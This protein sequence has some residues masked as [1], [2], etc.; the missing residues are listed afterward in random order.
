MAIHLAKS[1]A[2]S[3]MTANW[4]AI[5]MKIAFGI[6]STRR[7]SPTVRVSPM[8]SRI[9]CTSGAIVRFRSNPPHDINSRG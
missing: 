5:P 8:P 9:T 2:P 3:G 6:V 4:S 7:K 1:S